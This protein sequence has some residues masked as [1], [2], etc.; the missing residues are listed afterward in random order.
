MSSVQIGYLVELDG[1]AV[2]ALEFKYDTKH[3]WRNHLLM[4]QKNPEQHAMN[5]NI[6]RTTSTRGS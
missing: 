1:A 3:I 2:K 6:R 5:T 4:S